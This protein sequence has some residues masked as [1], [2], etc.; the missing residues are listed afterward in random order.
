MNSNFDPRNKSMQP[1]PNH[2]SQ[3]NAMQRD[4][5]E[6]LSAYLDGEVTAT[7]RKQVEELLATDASMQQLQNRLLKLRQGFRSLPTPAPTQSVEQTVDQV[8]AKID[9]RPKLRLV[10]GGATAVAALFVGALT[11]FTLNRPSPEMAT[12][13]AKPGVEQAQQ[14]NDTE[15]LLISLEQPVVNIPKN[16]TSELKVPAGVAPQTHRDA[17]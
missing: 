16:A 6:L 11:L 10:W 2:P 13:Q 9:Q 7:E 14:S 12:N 4:R 3:L 1:S 15:G 8:L 17:Q 5:F